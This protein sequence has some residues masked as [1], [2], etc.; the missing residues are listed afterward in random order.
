MPLKVMEEIIALLRSNQGLNVDITGGA[1]ELHPHIEDFISQCSGLAVSISL[2]SNLTALMHNRKIIKT[3]IDNRVELICSLPDISAEKTDQQRGKGVFENSVHILR[4]LNNKGYGHDIPLHLAHN[5]TDFVLPELQRMI[6][7]RYR[8]YLKTEYGVA[9]NRLFIL[10]NMP[11]GR[12]KKLLDRQKNYAQ[13]MSDLS[14][15]FNPS[16]VCGLMCRYILNIGWDGRLYDCDFNNALG[17]QIKGGF[18]LKGLHA[19]ALT[20]NDIHICD[21]CYGCTAV[22]G[23]GCFGT[24]VK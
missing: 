12:F 3:L 2:R 21:H 10:N 4:I 18:K 17:L 13:Y 15:N 9:F 24:V 8:D 20:G 16:T 1:P 5:P 11:V 23:S 19:A 7:N 6:E 14:S 22:K